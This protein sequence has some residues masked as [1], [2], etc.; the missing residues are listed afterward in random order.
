MHVEICTKGPSLPKHIPVLTAKTAPNAFTTST[1]SD[2]N[3]GIE[4]PLKM[5]LISGI[6]FDC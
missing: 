1:L 3:D 4:K 6:L 5:V 2:K